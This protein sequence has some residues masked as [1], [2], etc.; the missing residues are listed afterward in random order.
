MKKETSRNTFQL[1]FV[2]L[3][4]LAMTLPAN[5]QAQKGY[6]ITLLQTLGGTFFSGGHGLDHRGNSSGAASRIGE[7]TGTGEFWHA[8]IWDRNGIPLD[9][10]INLPGGPNDWGGDFDAVLSLNDR[11]QAAGW[12][13]TNIPD[14]FHGVRYKGFLWD[15]GNVIPL[16]PLAGGSLSEAVGINARGEVFGFSDTGAPNP[17]VGASLR[18]TLW[19]NGVITD[20]GTLGGDFGQARG[21]NNRSQVVGFSTTDVQNPFYPFRPFLWENG[22]MKDLGTLGGPQGDAFGI[23]DNGSI[24]G[25]SDTDEIGV[26]GFPILRATVWRRGAV[27]ELATPEGF[28]SEANHINNA[29]Q[30]VGFVVPP[31]GVPHAALWDNSQAQPVDLNSLIPEDSGWELLFANNINENGMIVGDGLYLGEQRGF[32]LTP[33]TEGKGNPHA[34]F[35]LSQ[36]KRNRGNIPLTP[37]E[38][39]QRGDFRALI[40]RGR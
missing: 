5:A 32:L 39:V 9:L 15:N 21:I 35:N 36:M 4:C 14:P 34:N 30:L 38:R 23:N 3:L 33:A 17:I 25:I 10:G 16:A 37:F 31:G 22:V 24:V 12:S 11:G 29:G 1:A 27:Q 18:S 7:N 26:D 2:T 6:N 8:A 19:R 20:L 13:A 40:P 28:Y